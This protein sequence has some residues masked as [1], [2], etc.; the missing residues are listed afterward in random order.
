MRL[1]PP[2]CSGVVTMSRKQLKEY[3]K[4]TFQMVEER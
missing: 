3:I 2:L 1:D 4:E